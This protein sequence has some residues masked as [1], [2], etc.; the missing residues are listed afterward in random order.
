MLESRRTL[1]SSDH[2]IHSVYEA[3]QEA[4]GS[5]RLLDLVRDALAPDFVYSDPVG[6]VL[7][8]DAF[9]RAVA[10]LPPVHSLGRVAVHVRDLGGHAVASGVCSVCL[11]DTSLPMTYRFNA[12]WRP[13]AS[14]WC[15]VAH[16]GDPALM[17]RP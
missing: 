13:A 3:W 15:C 5:D 7:G 10:E 8:R 16:R 14:A 12:L 2:F 11:G 1:V 4:V 9:L 6:V 17:S